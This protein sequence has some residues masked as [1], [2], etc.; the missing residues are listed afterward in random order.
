MPALHQ[1]APE[2]VTGRRSRH[3]P[4]AQ[5]EQGGGA[6]AER[7]GGDHHH[8]AGLGGPDQR[9][10]QR[11][12]EQGGER[13]R[14]PQHAVGT[15]DVPGDQRDGG[16]RAR[17]EHRPGRARHEEQHV[18]L[19]DLV[20]APE[21]QDGHQHAGDQVGEVRADHHPAG[22][23]PVRQ[24]A[25]D[26]DQGREGAHPAG[27]RVADGVEAVAG[28]DQAGGDRDRE[29]R[30]AE[31][32]AAAGREVEPEVAGPDVRAGRRLR[33]VDLCRWYVLCCWYVLCWWY[34]LDMCHG[35]QFWCRPMAGTSAARSRSG[36]IRDPCGESRSTTSVRG[37]AARHDGGRK[38]SVER[39]RRRRDGS[40]VGY[41]GCGGPGPTDRMAAGCAH[42]EPGTAGRHP[43]ATH[44][45]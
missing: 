13:L 43:P 29:H 44:G 26:Q 14:D 33:R 25:A 7:A 27:E 21:E 32:P 40:G 23:E 10:R 38:Q 1:V 22:G 4:E 16:R 35:C 17:L 24:D 34:V 28:A 9:A 6:E 2:A 39:V 19:P 41:D 31:Q 11:R 3:R 8:P 37:A 42:P 45:P 15:L 36:S 30:V 5:R 20:D 18:Q 12:A